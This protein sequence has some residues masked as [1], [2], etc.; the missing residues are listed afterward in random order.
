M[1]YAGGSLYPP[2]TIIQAS[3]RRYIVHKDGSLRVLDY[4]PAPTPILLS[5]D[6]LDAVAEE[7]RIRTAT[8]KGGA[9]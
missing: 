7:E 5:A 3:D 2:G 4:Q 1:R 6:D 9:A 8:E